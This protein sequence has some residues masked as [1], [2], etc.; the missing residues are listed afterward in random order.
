MH[1]L[2]SRLN[3]AAPSTQETLT[4]ADILAA[5]NVK[6]FPDGQAVALEAIFGDSATFDAGGAVSGTE[7]FMQVE[8]CRPNA[9]LNAK[10]IIGGG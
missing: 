4:D 3:A 6:T 8:W 9:V 7:A 5:I 1:R 10:L 2:L